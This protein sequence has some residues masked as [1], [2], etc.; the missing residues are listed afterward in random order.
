MIL[1]T[2]VFTR[3]RKISPKFFRPKFF[4]GRPRGTSVAKCLF[5]QD[6]EDPDRSFWADVRRDVRPK[7]SVFGLIF[8]FLIHMLVNH[9]QSLEDKKGVGTG[10]IRHQGPK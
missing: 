7:T 2:M 3:E 1:A 4:R 5:F 10:I 6:L 9:N 8:R